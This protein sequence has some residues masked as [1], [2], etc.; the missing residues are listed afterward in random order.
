MNNPVVLIVKLFFIL[1][2][3]SCNNKGKE[4]IIDL[5][6]NIEQLVLSEFVEKIEYVTLNTN[7]SCLISDIKKIYFDDDTLLVLDS[8]RGG[9][10][11]FGKN[12]QM[13]KQINYY[14]NGPKEFVT[15]T[16]LGIDKKANLIHIWDYP[17]QKISLFNYKGDFIRSIK[18]ELF[19]RDFIPLDNNCKLCI[20]PFYSKSLP[21]GIWVTD[22]TDVTLTRFEIA[23][24]DAGE[25]IEF[26]GTY[27][28]IM[29]EGI[30][31]YD[32]NYEDLYFIVDTGIKQIYSFDFKQRLPNSERRKN[33]SLLLPFNG[34]GYLSNFSMSEDYML[35]TFHYYGDDSP[36]R[37]V[38]FN[39]KNKEIK[40]SITLFNDIDFIQST[41][42]H[43]HFVNEEMWCRIIP[44]EN[45]C[46]I[47][48]QKLYLK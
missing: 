21:Y 24:P 7:D 34:F 14:G 47:L 17:G 16:A 9:V 12:G 4:C 1:F 35:M 25:Q 28:N 19:V 13:I 18:T 41:S 46:S 26:S 8:K 40:T 27:C 30:F 3:L 2:L 15:I 37:W 31:Y 42:S 23:I 32:R 44:E 29:N 38:L 11:T 22:S 33:P 43:V 10:F 39:R 20:L 48:L 6:N 5:E 45:N 36:N